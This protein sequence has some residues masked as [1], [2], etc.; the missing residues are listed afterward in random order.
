LFI[1]FWPNS[2]CNG[3]ASSSMIDSIV[4]PLAGQ[5]GT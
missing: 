4:S 1:S 2:L 5:M 3:P